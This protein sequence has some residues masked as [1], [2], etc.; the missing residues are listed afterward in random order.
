MSESLAKLE[1]IKIADVESYH[2]GVTA[3]SK[4]TWNDADA[5]WPNVRN[6]FLKHARGSLGFGEYM[7]YLI[8][9]EI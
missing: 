8:A 7:T 5:Q 2:T 3:E 1:T 4:S 9:Y 6:R